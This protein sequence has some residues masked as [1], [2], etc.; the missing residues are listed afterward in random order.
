MK[1]ISIEYKFSDKPTKN[2][3]EHPL[4][5]LLESLHSQGSIG[6][7]AKNLGRSYR[8]VWGELKSWEAQLEASLVVWGQNGKAAV[9]TH[10]AVQYLNAVYKSQ[11]E[12]EPSITQIKKHV[13][14]NTRIIRWSNQEVV[15][16]QKSNS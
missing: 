1:Y 7:A 4:V 3:I 14:K 11:V 8:H 12:L 5:Q 2:R 13:L 16:K 10:E 6:G 9:L 15:S